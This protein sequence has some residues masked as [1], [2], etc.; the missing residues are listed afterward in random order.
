MREQ[1]ELI[2]E[3]PP[4][5]KSEDGSL[6]KQAGEELIQIVA[7]PSWRLTVKNALILDYLDEVLEIVRG[8]N[9]AVEDSRKGKR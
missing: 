9:R 2:E 6:S 5:L 7:E 4:H 3:I 1:V 8:Y